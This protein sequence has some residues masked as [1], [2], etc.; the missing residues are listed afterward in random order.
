MGWLA[1]RSRCMAA[2]PTV[3]RD[4]RNGWRAYPMCTLHRG[5][6]GMHRGAW[7]VAGGGEIRWADR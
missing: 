3:E 1:S 2:G 4:E 5:H 6:G 7:T